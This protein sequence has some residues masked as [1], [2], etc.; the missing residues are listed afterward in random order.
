[1]SGT[2]KLWCFLLL[3]PF[4]AAMG[5]DFYANYLSDN[6]KK[7][8]LEALDINPEE[9]QASDAGWLFLTYTPDLYEMARDTAG[10]EIWKNKID[11]V[12]RQNTY[13]L[14]LIPAALFYIYLILARI[15]GFYPFGRGFNQKTQKA[16]IFQKHEIGSKYK[17]KRR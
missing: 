1:M 16:D 2:I 14:A 5:H 17:Y 11:P 9:Y 4:I 12:L 15:I 10:E 8:K 3:L 7:A 13:V 6:D